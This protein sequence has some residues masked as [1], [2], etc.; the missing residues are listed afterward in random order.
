M[1]EA[2]DIAP[3]ERVPDN[4]RG[5][6]FEVCPIHAICWEL[7]DIPLVGFQWVVQ[8]R[9][10][11]WAI[12]APWQHMVPP[13]P[14]APQWLQDQFRRF[15]VTGRHDDENGIYA[16]GKELIYEQ[17]WLR[18]ASEAAKDLARSGGSLG[19]NRD[20][21]PG[22]HPSVR[23]I[24]RSKSLLKHREIAL[25]LWNHT[26]LELHKTEGPLGYLSAAITKNKV[27]TKTNEIGLKHRFTS[28]F[29]ALSCGG[30]DQNT[31][32]SDYCIFNT[33]EDLI[34]EIVLIVQ[35]HAIVP[36]RG[37]VSVIWF[38]KWDIADNFHLYP[39]PWRY[40][41]VQSFIHPITDE[42]SRLRFFAFGVTNGPARA[43]DFA[44]FIVSARARGH[45][46]TA[47]A[48]E[49]GP[50]LYGPD[51]PARLVVKVDD[52]VSVHIGEEAARE[53]GLRHSKG[54]VRN[55]GARTKDA[56]DRVAIE[57]DFDG[58]TIRPE[59]DDL[60][61]GDLK[62]EFYYASLIELEGGFAVNVAIEGPFVAIACRLNWASRAIRGGRA[63]IIPFFSVLYPGSK[64][65]LAIDPMEV[66]AGG[67]SVTSIRGDPFH[68]PHDAANHWSQGRKLAL[69]AI[70]VSGRSWNKRRKLYISPTAS[71]RRCVRWWLMNMIE[72]NGRRMFLY[73]RSPGLLVPQVF[74]REEHAAIDTSHLLDPFGRTMCPMG[75]VGTWDAATGSDNEDCSMGFG[76]FGSE[77]FLI[78]FPP[79]MIIL[80]LEYITGFY[81]RH[82]HPFEFFDKYDPQCLT[83]RRLVLRGDNS[84]GLDAR[85]AGHCSH[86][87]TG[88]WLVDDLERE[89]RDVDGIVSTQAWISTHWN[90]LADRGSR[91]L[92]RPHT[93]D[94]HF[95]QLAYDSVVRPL[96]GSRGYTVESH[97]SVLG[98]NC[99]SARWGHRYCPFESFTFVPDDDVLINMPFTIAFRETKAL[100]A[101]Q[102]LVPFAFTYVFPVDAP[103]M[104]SSRH[105]IRSMLVCM[106][107]HIAHTWWVD[108]QAD[109]QDNHTVFI[110]RKTTYIFPDSTP[111]FAPPLPLRWTV[112][113]WRKD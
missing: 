67:H 9:D 53:D 22:T 49:N 4:A 13:E 6:P 42:V 104:H 40:A 58:F 89:A 33:I 8:V 10:T 98:D 35:A 38:A 82:V 74:T 101:H 103:S 81:V 5:P 79:G 7:Q 93:D 47:L 63:H 105:A 90:T 2:F 18:C 88:E 43:F 19:Y 68:D 61:L 99:R 113:L 73:W 94:Y 108:S 86:K 55:I 20:I 110:G 14:A 83:D 64:N 39:V 46:A 52:F 16:P 97:A 56:K 26:D 50:Q 24:Q 85:E 29:Q 37:F 111:G 54:L 45:G 27:L 80:L 11:L 1:L 48:L 41:D 75:P 92:V 21:Q 76:W 109:V 112:E 12:H 65:A 106:G 71:V 44:A 95:T 51:P 62:M 17:C 78:I 72:C 96:A 15:K 87:A 31:A 102:C 3:S 69:N 34:A 30:S 32:S 84:P 77:S 60:V 66:L 91:G 59:T 23:S 28:S 107:A 57:V 100:R 70:P 36:V 25:D